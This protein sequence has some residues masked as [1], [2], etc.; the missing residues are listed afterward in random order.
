MRPKIELP[1]HASIISP[2]AKAMTKK[3]PQPLQP[4]LEVVLVVVTLPSG[5][6][7]VVVF[8]TGGTP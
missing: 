5:P 6:V 7:T 2:S 4:P 1:C 8:F 3:V